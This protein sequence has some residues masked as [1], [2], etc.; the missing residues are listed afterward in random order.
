MNFSDIMLVMSWAFFKAMKNIDDL[1]SNVEHMVE[2][3]YYSFDNIT[4]IYY[5]GMNV[6]F[7]KNKINNALRD[8]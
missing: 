3:Q 6:L 8:F 1:N 4:K 5:H 2:L 7:Y